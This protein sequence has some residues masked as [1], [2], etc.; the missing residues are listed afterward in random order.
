MADFVAEVAMEMGVRRGRRL[1]E[2]R[3]ARFCRSLQSE[4][5]R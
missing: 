3:G 2:C 1:L 4:R 5:R